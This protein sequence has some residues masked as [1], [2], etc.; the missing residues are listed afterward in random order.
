MESGQLKAVHYVCT[1]ERA[2]QTV[3]ES[4]RVV[5]WGLARARPNAAC[6][7]GMHAGRPSMGWVMDIIGEYGILRDS[8]LR[9]QQVP[10]KNFALICDIQFGFVHIA[11]LSLEERPVAWVLIRSTLLLPSLLVTWCS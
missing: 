9:L 8:L 11:P 4:L 5:S 7:L 3:I 10:A 6:L 1:H 2:T